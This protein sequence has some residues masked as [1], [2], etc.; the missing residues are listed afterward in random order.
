MIAVPLEPESG[1]RITFQA[2]WREKLG[3]EELAA[4]TSMLVTLGRL[5]AIAQRTEREAITPP[6]RRASRRRW[7]QSPMACS[8]AAETTCG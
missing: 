5:T 2:G 6:P 4:A 8:S 1:A 7:E 3:G